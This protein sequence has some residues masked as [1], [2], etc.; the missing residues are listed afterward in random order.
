MSRRNCQHW[1]HSSA[2]DLLANHPA[3]L[4]AIADHAPR[5]GIDD[6]FR[7]IVRHARDMYDLLVEEIEAQEPDVD[8]EVRRISQRTLVEV[9]QLEALSE[10]PRGPMM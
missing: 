1:P 10:A 5:F 2:Y 3:L 7:E 9:L 8:G 6:E 4:A